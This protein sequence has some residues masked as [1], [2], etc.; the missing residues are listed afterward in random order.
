MP[1]SQIAFFIDMYDLALVLGWVD[2]A[3]YLEFAFPGCLRLIYSRLKLS[4]L[5]RFL[6]FSRGR[7]F[8]CWLGFCLRPLL[9]GR[10]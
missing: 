4:F 2:I 5:F 6:R 8:G 9:T 1:E 7:R 3:V 10:Y